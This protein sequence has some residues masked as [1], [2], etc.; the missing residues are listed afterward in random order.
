MQ[1]NSACDKDTESIVEHLILQYVF[2]TKILNEKP[3]AWHT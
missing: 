3:V 1:R 2:M